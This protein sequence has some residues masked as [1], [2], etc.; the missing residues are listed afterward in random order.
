MN[1]CLGRSAVVA[2]LVTLGLVPAHARSLQ[3]ISERGTLTLCANPDALPF[4][5]RIG[6]MPGFQIELADQL[7]HELG[8]SLTREWVRSTYQV[9]RSDCD[10]V[11]DAIMHAEAKPEGPVRLSRPYHRGGVV[12]AV[13]ADSDLSSL[14]QL[15]PGERVGVALGSVVS[16]MLDKRHIAITP[17]VLE[18]QIVAALADREI[19]AA[20]VTPAT[21]GWFNLQHRDAPL[22]VVPV[23]ADDPDLN[24]NIAAGLIRSDEELRR[25]VDQ[26]LERLLS[27]GT[28][29]KIYARYGIELRAPQ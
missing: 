16:M 6:A 27:D 10:L 15:K 18:D 25:R 28:I 22:R 19:A 12:L 9:R 13:R 26:A 5:S 8:V 1:R 29:A 2:A 14:E 20:A 17:F 11:L 3:A 4:A 24:W 21:V 7:A 23:F